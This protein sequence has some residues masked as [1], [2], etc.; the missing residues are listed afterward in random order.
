MRIT[1]IS[2]NRP[3]RSFENTVLN[4]LYYSFFHSQ[5]QPELQMKLLIY[6][7]RLYK[8]RYTK[9]ERGTFAQLDAML[10]EKIKK[11]RIPSQHAT[12]FD[13]GGD[14]I[15]YDQAQSSPEGFQATWNRNRLSLTE[16]YDLRPK[17]DILSSE[18]YQKLTTWMN[19]PT[20]ELLASSAFMIMIKDCHYQKYE[21]P[22]RKNGNDPHESFFRTYAI[23]EKQTQ[24]PQYDVLYTS[25]RDLLDNLGIFDVE[26]TTDEQKREEMRAAGRRHG[27]DS[28]LDLVDTLHILT[29]MWEEKHPGS[30]F[31]SPLHS[32]T[33]I[34]K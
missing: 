30:K 15:D 6:N 3:S 8:N 2:E 26:Y 23:E 1:E 33:S 21:R 27:V 9:A 5:Q 17:L 14:T 13:Y 10:E 16:V 29:D 11:L 34:A 12:T 24:S 22:N 31:L 19:M 32:D 28:S 7:A 18:A 4:D 20:P 25:L